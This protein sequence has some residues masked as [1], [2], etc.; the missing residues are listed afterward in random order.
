MTDYNKSMNE[1]KKHLSLSSLTQGGKQWLINSTHLTLNLAHKTLFFDGFEFLSYFFHC[2]HNIAVQLVDTDIIII[3]MWLWI[4]QCY[5]SKLI[6]IWKP[7]PFVCCLSHCYK[8]G[9][10]FWASEVYC[11]VFSVQSSDNVPVDIFHLGFKAAKMCAIK[12]HSDILCGNVQHWC[13]TLN[14]A[15]SL[16]RAD[17]AVG[18]L[19]KF[20]YP[21]VTHKFSLDR[22]TGKCVRGV[23]LSW[24][25]IK[26]LE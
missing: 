22:V 23:Y 7:T 8:V 15:L 2:Y 25:M 11:L 26:L 10:L 9:I 6:W 18:P 3:L 17:S 13:R 12:E 14:T 5:S 4:S 19:L 20:I 1:R 21:T 16:S 24:R